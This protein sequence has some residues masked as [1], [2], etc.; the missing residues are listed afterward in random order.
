[1]NVPEDLKYNMQDL[2]IKQEGDIL[3]IG[4]TD[5]A[6][7]Q[8]SDVVFTEFKASVGEKVE[9]GKLIAVVESVK[10]SSDIAAPLNGKVLE[11]ND[12][13]ISSPE[14]INEDPYGGA[15]L[16]K[17]QMDQSAELNDLIDAAT[18]AAYRIQ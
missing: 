1:M 2:W 7:D 6:Q 9:K 3:T 4:I 10:A 8:L 11:I 13:V 18:Y 16:I 17:M 15:W 5:Y 12:E 14:R